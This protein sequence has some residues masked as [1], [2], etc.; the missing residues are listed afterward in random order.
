MNAKLMLGTSSRPWRDKRYAGGIFSDAGFQ[1]AWD[2]AR[3]QPGASAGVTLYS[4][5]KQGIAVGEGSP[6]EQV[7]KLLPGLEKAFPGAEWAYTGKVFRMHWPSHAFTKASYA[8]YRSGQWSTINGHEITPVGNLH[9]AGEHCSSDF[10]GYMNGGA[11]TGR[12]AAEAI[13]AAVR[14]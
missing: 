7:E 3:L 8:C 14:R 1:L 9:F 5:G 4:G 10:Q 12:V 13:L 11:E 2:N 6:R